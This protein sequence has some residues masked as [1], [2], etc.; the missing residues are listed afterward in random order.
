MFSLRKLSPVAGLS[1]QILS[2]FAKFS[3][4]VPFHYQELFELAPDKKT[5]YRKLSGE[6]VSTVDFNG[7]KFLKIEPEAIRLLSAQAMVDIAHLLRPAHLQQL[8][9]IL[10]DPEATSNDKFVALELLKNANIASHFI[11]PGCQDTG[12]AIVSG[13]RGQHVLTD[14]E[15]EKHISRGVYDTYTT[16]NLRYSQVAP[17]DMYKE[18]NTKTNL[19]AQIDLYASKGNEYNFLYIAKGGGSAN[20]TYL[21]QQTKALLNPASL[22]SFLEEKIKTL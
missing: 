13:K 16:T 3:S 19:P 7:T 10:K 21:F 5:V 1:R 8:S 9:N 12:T 20:K 4:V 11:L 17:T 22:M 14:G 15:D 6:H 2:K 18:V